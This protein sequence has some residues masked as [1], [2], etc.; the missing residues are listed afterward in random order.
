MK[1]RERNKKDKQ[2]QR[3]KERFPNT[4]RGEK[5]PKKS[6]KIKKH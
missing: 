6:E 3:N 4:I 5:S 2:T 1:T